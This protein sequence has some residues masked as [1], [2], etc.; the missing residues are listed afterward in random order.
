MQA[1]AIIVV[2]KVFQLFLK[3]SFIPEHLVIKEFPTDGRMVKKLIRVWSKNSCGLTMV[4]F[5]QSTQSFPSANGVVVPARMASVPG[6]EPL[7]RR[8]ACQNQM[9]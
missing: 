8:K 2:L 5:Q 1:V 4:V 9:S 7:L 3:I 6:S